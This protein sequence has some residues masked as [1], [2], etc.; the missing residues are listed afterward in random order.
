MDLLAHDSGD[1]SDIAGAH[2]HR[3]AGQGLSASHTVTSTVTSTVTMSLTPRSSNRL[4]T[5][6]GLAA[7]KGIHMLYIYIYCECC[8]CVC[9]HTHTHNIHTYFIH[10]NTQCYA[11]RTSP[12]LFS[13]LYTQIITKLNYSATHAG[14]HQGAWQQRGGDAR[15]EGGGRWCCW[16]WECGGGCCGVGGGR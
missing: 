7:S 4:G 3:R 16:K 12:S 10:T 11:R 13:Y 8:E 6:K 2:S 1:K 9:V 5:D 14:H 15:T